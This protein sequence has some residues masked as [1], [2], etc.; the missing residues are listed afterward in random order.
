LIYLQSDTVVEFKSRKRQKECRGWS[1]VRLIKFTGNVFQRFIKHHSSTTHT[2]TR[3]VPA[4]VAAVGQRPTQFYYLYLGGEWATA[5]VREHGIRADEAR[6]P[7]GG[8]AVVPLAAHHESETIVTFYRTKQCH[9]MHSEQPH[10][11][12]CLITGAPL[13][14]VEK[15]HKKRPSLHVHFT[16]AC[17][18]P[19]HYGLQHL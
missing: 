5:G 9:T 10:I 8:A 17:R 18:L 1:L 4:H 14:F 15:T 2:H 13:P 12:L 11:S 3:S 6:Q 7:F 19:S 16:Y